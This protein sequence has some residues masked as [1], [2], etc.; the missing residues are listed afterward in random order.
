MA[1]K[2]PQDRK[3]AKGARFTFHSDGKKYTLPLV[4]EAVAKLSGGDLMDSALGGDLGRI[5]YMF[6][7]LS[8]A[9]APEAT[10]VLRAMSPADMLEIINAWG[11]FGDGEGAS[12]GE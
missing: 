5:E 10:G 8:A 3:P 12:L 2:Q 6:K 7:A 11:E 4:S 1:A 9:D